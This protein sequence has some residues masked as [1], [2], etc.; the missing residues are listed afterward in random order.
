MRCRIICSARLRRTRASPARQLALAVEDEG[1]RRHALG[2][3][4]VALLDDDEKRVFGAQG[5][6]SRTRAV[7]PAQSS[8]VC[9]IPNA[10]VRKR[11]SRLGSV[12]RS[13]PVAARTRPLRDV[14]HDLDIPVLFYVGSRDVGSR[15][16]RS[17]PNSSM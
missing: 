13:D 2:H 8:T 15:D 11:V 9:T 16:V 4:G 17:E 14:E 5:R 7:R 12:T 3:P 10:L 1:G 6:S